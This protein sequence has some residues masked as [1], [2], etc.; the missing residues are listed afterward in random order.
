MVRM[1]ISCHTMTNPSHRYYGHFCS[2]CLS[3]NVSIDNSTP[4]QL[5]AAS[6]TELKQQMIW[7]I[8]SL[9]PGRHTVNITLD[10]FD[11]D[12]KLYGSDL[13]LDFFR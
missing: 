12:S 13:Y 4:Q 10:R 7:S 5:H 2:T 8:T 9:D 3:F 11:H 1:C 6:P